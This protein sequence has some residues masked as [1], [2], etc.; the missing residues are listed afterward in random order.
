MKM[1]DR[2]L[3]REWYKSARICLEWLNP[4]VDLDV[5]RYVAELLDR[6][7]RVHAN[8]IA[9]L[10][11]CGGYI[12][13]DGQSAPKDTHVGKYD[14][15]EMLEKGAHEKGLRFIVGF[16][17][18][19]GNAYLSNEYPFWA[20]VDKDGNI[21]TRYNF[22]ILCPNSP[23]GEYYPTYIAEVLCRYQVDGIYIE[24]IYF[25]PGFCFCPYCREKFK[26][27]YGKD[28]AVENIENDGE[29][30]TFRQDS[31]TEF[32]R[33]VRTVVDDSSPRTIVAAS[34]YSLYEGLK[35]SNIETFAR[36]VD[37]VA[38]ESQWGYFTSDQPLREIGLCNL[39]MKAEGKKHVL[40]TQF[41]AKQQ[42]Y[43]FAPRSEAHLKVALMEN[44]SHA[45]SLQ[46]HVQNAFEE[47]ESL[48]PALKEVFTD[49]ETMSPYLTDA[50]PLKYAALLDCGSLGR[51]EDYFSEA[52]RGFY[53]TL[54]EYHMPVNVITTEDIENDCLK[55]YAVL[56]LANVR[57]PVPTLVDAMERYVRNGGG[58]VMTYQTAWGEKSGNNRLMELV[59]IRSRSRVV[60]NL[61]T[62]LAIC[63]ERGDD[64]RFPNE[65]LPHTYYRINSDEKI[66]KGLNRKLLSF[67]GG[68]AAVELEK[69]ISPAAW[70]LDFD[71]GR[72]HRDHLILGGYPGKAV[73]PMIITGKPGKGRVVYIAGDLDAA[74]CRLGCKDNM[75]VLTDSVAW[76]AADEVPLK[77]NCPPSV[78]IVGHVK[79]DMMLI[80]LLNQTTNQLKPCSVVRYVVPL[81]GIRLSVTIGDKTPGEVK[82][83][84]GSPLTFRKE[85][86]TL[87]ISLDKL[88]EYEAIMVDFLGSSPESVG[89]DVR[90]TPKMNTP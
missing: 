35:D 75:Q 85:N 16:F 45:T 51:K 47:D 33:K 14:L 43:D 86:K 6:V 38:R 23:F 90:S 26:G 84:K 11:D 54:T 31:I 72:R 81:S 27:K 56:I 76:A 65:C 17:G 12:L 89:H 40:N 2:I 42:D 64:E 80:M 4:K 41:V 5:E 69:G 13:Y 53:L 32:F 48:M 39:I 44:L 66:W 71:P 78:E 79:P 7:E 15:M 3:D 59:G 82:S 25:K 88:N 83:L 29:F 21:E 24:G 34:N 22:K 20:Q 9:H 37:V 1:K 8:A 28:P 68:Y 55:N 58:L 67:R 52:L 87:I 77:T 61:Q 63:R 49:V 50:E 60:S 46:I 18:Q 10:A 57:N 73:N 19:Q 70:V 30:S 62:H 74:C 36:Y